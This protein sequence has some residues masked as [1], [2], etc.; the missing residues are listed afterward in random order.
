MVDKLKTMDDS[1]PSVKNFD[2]LLHSLVVK[3]KEESR[4]KMEMEAKVAMV[5]NLV[6]L[7]I[8]GNA[9]RAQKMK[10]MKNK[11]PDYNPVTLKTKEIL[12]GFQREF[13]NSNKKEYGGFIRDSKRIS[14]KF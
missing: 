3:A 10:N 13:G 8:K 1:A 14:R 12:E 4:T 2:Q 9:L 6:N 7:F 5:D 11:K